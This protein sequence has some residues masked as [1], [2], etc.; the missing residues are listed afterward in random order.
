[1]RGRVIWSPRAEREYFSTLTYW[2]NRNGSSEYSKKIITEIEKL[3]KMLLEYPFS[4]PIVYETPQKKIRRA[5]V[6]NNFSIFYKAFPEIIE[7][8]FFFDNRDNPNK[9]KF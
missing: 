9:L 8:V 3:E 5:L 2:K 1:M 6:L 4:C 7:I